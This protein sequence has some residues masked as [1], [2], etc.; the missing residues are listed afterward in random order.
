MKKVLFVVFAFATLSFSACSS[1]SNK[2][3]K[4]DST[5]VNNTVNDVVNA[6][7]D[8]TNTMNTSKMAMPDTAKKM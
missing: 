8:S 7:K 5:Q 1:G 4:M 6:V 2:T 3:E